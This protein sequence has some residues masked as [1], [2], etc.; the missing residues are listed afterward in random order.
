MRTGQLLAAAILAL[1]AALPIAASSPDEGPSHEVYTYSCKGRLTAAIP[2]ASLS[3]D[4]VWHSDTA[5]WPTLSPRQALASATKFLQNSRL[6]GENFSPLK[7]E[8]AA[9]DDQGRT[10]VY[11]VHFTGSTSCSTENH[12]DFPFSVIPVLVT[13]EVI[14]PREPTQQPPTP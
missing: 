8:M 9:C 6:I 1:S 3:Y 7:I 2:C 10:W 11:L 5:D 13:G 4:A 14:A 12:P